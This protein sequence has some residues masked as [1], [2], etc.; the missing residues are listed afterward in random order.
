MPI[1][2]PLPRH[3]LLALVLVVVRRVPTLR[4]RLLLLL[5]LIVIL[6]VLLLPFG[7]PMRRKKLNGSRRS[8]VFV[9]RALV[10]EAR[11]KVGRDN[12]LGLAACGALS[13]LRGLVFPIAVPQLVFLASSVLA[14][15]LFPPAI[16]FPDKI[17]EDQSLILLL[18]LLL[19]EVSS[20]LFLRA[21]SDTII[22]CVD[23]VPL[24]AFSML[25]TQRQIV[26][27]QIIRRD[28]VALPSPHLSG[29][30]VTRSI[31]AFKS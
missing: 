28:S 20:C 15:P 21:Q 13:H 1:P 16:D 29:H 2:A 25:P 6:V 8:H 22:R 17:L 4:C 9:R 31:T 12:C 26:Q 24:L 11:A 19:L 18:H 10:P 23:H 3:L 5:L 14:H 30:Q 7:L 27:R